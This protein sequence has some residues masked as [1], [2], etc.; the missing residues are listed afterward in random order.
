M[1]YFKHEKG[2]IALTAPNE[3]KNSN[4]IIGIL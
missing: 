1:I 2:R 3:I 4:K